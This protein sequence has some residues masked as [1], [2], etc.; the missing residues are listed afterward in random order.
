[1]R[2]EIRMGDGSLAD[3]VYTISS[4]LDAEDVSKA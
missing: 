3:G 2:G 4:S 1:M